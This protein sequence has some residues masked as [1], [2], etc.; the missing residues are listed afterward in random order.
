MVSIT[1]ALIVFALYMYLLRS[2]DGELY[3]SWDENLLSTPFRNLQS[4]ADFAVTLLRLFMLY[5][6]TAAMGQLKWH[7]FRRRSSRP[8]SDLKAFDDASR[9]IS[10]SLQLIFS[11]NML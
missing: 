6:V 5:P 11:R 7:Y 2:Y 1:I 8:V 3:D 4:A 9:G 10:G